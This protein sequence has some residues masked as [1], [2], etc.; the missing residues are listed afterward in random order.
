MSDMGQR[1]L[2]RNELIEIN[3]GLRDRITKLEQENESFKVLL[4]DS[5]SALAIQRVRLRLKELSTENE[6]L[7][8][9]LKK[10]D[11]EIKRGKDDL[12]HELRTAERLED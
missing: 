5:E 1:E 12:H 10:K 6:S 9:Q 11:E 3:V 2:T 4:A 8:K 7:N